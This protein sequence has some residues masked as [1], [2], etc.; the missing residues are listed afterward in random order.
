MCEIFVCF[1]FISGEVGNCLDTMDMD[2]VLKTAI[3][4]EQFAIDRFKRLPIAAIF[5][6]T[7]CLTIGSAILEGRSLSQTKKSLSDGLNVSEYGCPTENTFCYQLANCTL[8]SS[9][10]VKMGDFDNGTMFSNG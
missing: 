3:T 1:D 5:M 10:F 7:F 4:Q 9:S 2:G 6:S 8:D